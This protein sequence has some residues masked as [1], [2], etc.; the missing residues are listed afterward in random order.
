MRLCSSFPTPESLSAR[1]VSH[2][3]FLLADVIVA[4]GLDV[5]D[6]EG[7]AGEDSLAELEQHPP[8][9]E[10]FAGECCHCKRAG[11]GAIFVKQLGIAQQQATLASRQPI[12]LRALQELGQGKFA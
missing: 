1:R 8:A 11:V 9:P 5:F 3:G 6:G 4:G 2:P 12:A 7:F 10:V